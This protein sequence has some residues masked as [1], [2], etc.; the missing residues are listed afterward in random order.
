M[1]LDS[2]TALARAVLTL[3]Q[4]R[5][6][7]YTKLTVSDEIENALSY[8]RSTF[9]RQIPK[10]YREV[11]HALPGRDILLHGYRPVTVIGPLLE[12]EAAQAH[13]GYWH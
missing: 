6:L 10:M 3:W 4:T 5:M 1:S 13:Q 12:D 2:E 11:E 7:R 8:Y 9:L